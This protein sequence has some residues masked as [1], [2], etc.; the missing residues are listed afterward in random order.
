MSEHGC[1]CSSTSQK[2]QNRVSLH[3]RNMFSSD[4]HRRSGSR[5][6][7]HLPQ[8]MWRT[9]CKIFWV[10]TI[11][12][13]CNILPSTTVSSYDFHS[14]S[15]DT[16]TN[17]KVVLTYDHPISKNRT[18]ESHEEYGRYGTGPMED[19]QGV[20]VHGKVAMGC[21]SYVRKNL[22]MPQKTLWIALVKRGNCSEWQKVTFAEALNASAVVIYNDQPGTE[23]TTITHSGT[24]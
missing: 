3:G 22:P 9:G 14:T 20:V 13:L 21:T 17:A 1:G 23:L 4:H 18:I 7:L 15:S 11:F 5:G 16:W 2:S 24:K 6:G 19:A 8:M 12:L 10:Q